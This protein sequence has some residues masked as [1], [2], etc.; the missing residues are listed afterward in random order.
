MSNVYQCKKCTVCC[1]N[2]NI[3]PKNKDDLIKQF[4]VAFGF[5]LK[6]YDIKVM[7]GGE[8]EHLK[9]NRCDIY[10]ERPQR[11]KDFI[12]K[13]YHKNNISDGQLYK[14]RCRVCQKIRSFQKGKE[15]D[16]QSVCGNCWVW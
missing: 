8:C 4:E 16:V 11:C 5:K 3:E 6:S 9:N 10:K 14:K 15:R 2:F 1:K 13:R 12:C 7:F